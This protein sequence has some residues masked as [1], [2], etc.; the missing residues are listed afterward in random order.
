[1]KRQKEDGIDHLRVAVTSWLKK[2]CDEAIDSTVAKERVT[3]SETC[4]LMECC[5]REDDGGR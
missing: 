2:N 4:A 3:V 1:M 5:G